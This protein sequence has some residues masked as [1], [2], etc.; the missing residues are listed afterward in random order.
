[1][2][3]ST[4]TLSGCAYQITA[5]P[6]DSGKIYT[7]QATETGFGGGDIEITIEA[8]IYKGKWT[9]TS[10][11]DSYTVLTTFGTNS[12]GARTT[13]TGIGQSYGSGG[14]GKAMLSSAD[15]RGLRCEF[16]GG[17]SGSGGGI[18]VDDAGRVFDI[19]YGFK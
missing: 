10:S 6:R 13:S 17:G 16:A 19:Q 7:G 15:G 18:C 12:R 11:N 8:T 1:M 9:T 4:L 3:A 5:M 14:T 2:I